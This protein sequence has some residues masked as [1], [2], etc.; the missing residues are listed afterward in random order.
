MLVY[1]LVPAA[2]ITTNATPTTEN[3]FAFTK[4]G[5]TR[6]VVLRSIQLI[7]RAPGLAAISGIVVRI[8]KW[9]TT[10]SSGGTA[11]TPAPTDSGYQAA[12]STAGF[13]AA[14]VTSGTGGPT[15][16]GTIGC[17]AGGPGGWT[18][19]DQDSGYTLEANDNKSIDL[20]NIAGT[21]S[22]N[23]EFEAQSAE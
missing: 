5:A 9:T 1:K 16:L 15:V 14:T 22:L 21:A 10:S 17:G 23:F 18:A 11:I 6:N 7:G 12:K 2:V 4:P 8:K 13:A 19:Q 20:F 3:D